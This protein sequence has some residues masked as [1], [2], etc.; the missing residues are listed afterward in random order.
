MT[1][2]E[3]QFVHFLLTAD[4][5]AIQHWYSRASNHDLI[6]ACELMERFAA[7]LDYELLSLTI[8][9]QIE[10]MPVLLEA[11]AVI[12]SVREIK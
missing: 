8:E 1:E 11:Q 3:Q 4:K 6:V 10:S 9:K 2:F 12:A 5:D 7:F